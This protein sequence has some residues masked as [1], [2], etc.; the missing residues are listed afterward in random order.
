M[1]VRQITRP[2]EQYE[3]TVDLWESV[4]VVVSEEGDGQVSQELF[5]EG[6]HIIRCEVRRPHKCAAIETLL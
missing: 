4:D 3:R 1:Y 6:R 2:Y 5:H